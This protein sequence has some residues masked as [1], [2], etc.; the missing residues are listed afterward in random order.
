MPAEKINKTEKIISTQTP[1]LS[2]TVSIVQKI[3]SLFMKHKKVSMVIIG[4]LIIFI[5][6]NFLFTK[7]STKD[8]TN[9]K[10]ITVQIDKSFDFPAITNNGKPS[11]SKI[12]LKITNVEKTS[13]VV[14]KD[15]VYAAK[16]NKMFLIA[17]LELKNDSTSAQN[18]LPGDLIRLS[19]GDNQD[20][21]FAPD[22][23][24]NLVPVSAI[25]TK[26]DRV[27]F[28]IPS[29]EKNFNLYV[30]E[31]EGKKETVSINFPS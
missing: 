15:Q 21:K 29:E 4:I 16:N 7:K 11:G 31:I 1:A 10:S 24:N 22:L 8:Q 30:G 28:V 14:V 26:I 27:G 17:N 5:G 2:K 20:T 13:Q 9:I 18:I 12:K 23:H 25:S 6:Y 3:F 19:I